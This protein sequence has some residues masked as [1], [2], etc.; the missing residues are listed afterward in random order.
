MLSIRM[1]R[2]GRKGFATYRVVVQDSR[3]SPDS[4]KVV[5][6]LGS[7]D[8]HAKTT[9]L[10][11]EKAEFYLEHGAQPSDR[12]VKLF[13]SEGIKLPKWVTPPAQQKRTT[14]TPDKLRKNRPAE[15]EAEKAPEEAPAEAA[16]PEAPEVETPETEVKTPAEETPTTEDTSEPANSADEAKDKN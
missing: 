8:P 5:A 12:V 3:Q 13:V 11:K 15:P 2:R 1:Q 6:S 4:G 9:S 16:K 14:R 10:V 7:Y